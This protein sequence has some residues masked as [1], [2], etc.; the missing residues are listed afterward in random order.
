MHRAKFASYEEACDFLFNQLPF[1]QRQGPKAL[2]FDLSNIIKL[3]T[4]L[5]NPHS[6]FKSIHI[7]GTNGKGTTAHLL[8]AAFQSAG[9]KTGLYTSPHF[10][11]FRERIKLNGTLLDKTFLFEFMNKHF[12]IIDEL[13]P[14]YFELSVAMAFEYFAVQKVDIAII[15]VGLGGRLDST[16]IILP[17]LTVITNISL[18]HTQTLGEDLP[19]I[20]REKAGIVKEKIP[21]VIG[22]KQQET[23]QVYQEITE[24][25]NAPLY[26]AEDISSPN[27]IEPG[28][29]LHTVGPFFEKNIRTAKAALLVFK[30]YHPEW[31]LSDQKINKGLKN[32]QQL[33]DYLGRWS[34]LG[35]DP[36]IVADGAHNI[37]AWEATTQYLE[38]IK[39]GNLH[40]VL[41][42]VFDKTIEQI[43][44]LL[45]TTA[46]YYFC[47]ADIPRALNSTDLKEK[48]SQYGLIGKAYPTVAEALKMA[49]SK[50]DRSD[51]IFVGGSIF[52]AG[53]IL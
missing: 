32:F 23:T 33:T 11:D 41:G 21:L 24:K 50:A 25:K 18:D 15:E 37:G 14:S 26:F 13:K 51:L 17:M 30:K 49:K 45:P 36:L 42:F 20:A 22:E 43:L 6:R 10:K 38:K 12:R 4:A 39:T 35:K 52:V 44:E 2:K 40:I 31:H 8:S 7:A 16:N 34:I 5:G 46:N 29:E 3:M 9:Y 19:T 47:H 1:Y 48:A 27:P 53:E 28:Q